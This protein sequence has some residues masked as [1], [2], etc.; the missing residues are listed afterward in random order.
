MGVGAQNR[1]NGKI[2]MEAVLSITCQGRLTN[3]A[4]IQHRLPCLPCVGLKN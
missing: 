3:Q 1:S 2:S 4:I